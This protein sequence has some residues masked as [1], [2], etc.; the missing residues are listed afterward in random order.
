MELG[1]ILELK[2]AA[3]THKLSGAAQQCLPVPAPADTAQMIDINGDAL[4]RMLAK[5]AQQLNT[6]FQSFSERALNTKDPKN[7]AP[8]VEAA[9]K[10]QTAAVRSMVAIAGLNAQR[11]GQAKVFLNDPGTGC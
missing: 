11:R 6:L 1:E 5:Q 3:R 9:V 4:L 7:V 10:C 2:E 8:L